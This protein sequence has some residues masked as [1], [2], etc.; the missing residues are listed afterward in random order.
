MRR[1]GHIAGEIAAG[2]VKRLPAHTEPRIPAGVDV[3]V[4]L[5][6]QRVHAGLAAT[7]AGKAVEVTGVVVAGTEHI[8]VQFEGVVPGANNQTQTLQW[9]LVKEQLGLGTLPARVTKL[10]H[11][12][13]TGVNRVSRIGEGESVL[14]TQN[15]EL[16]QVGFEN[17]AFGH[18]T[19]QTQSQRQ[20]VALLLGHA[21]AG[22]GHVVLPAILH[23]VAAPDRFAGRIAQ[24]TVGAVRAIEAIF[25]GHVQQG[26]PLTEVLADLE[27]VVVGQCVLYAGIAEPQ[28]R[29]GTLIIADNAA[30]DGS[31]GCR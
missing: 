10:R 25:V 20:T 2:A 6:K 3:P 24:V 17:D 21:H 23:D 5:R 9:Q 14:V 8:H 1:A 27:L 16:I 22:S 29:D 26:L 4:Q 12:A 7:A 28:A 18:R 15:L 31:H 13:G 19:P 30:A 11:F